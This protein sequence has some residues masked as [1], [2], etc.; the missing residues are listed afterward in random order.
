MDMQLGLR[1]PGDKGM[2]VTGLTGGGYGALVGQGSSRNSAPAHTGR[3]AG[4]RLIDDSG[5]S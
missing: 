1:Q 3:N 4:D 5:S 2:Q